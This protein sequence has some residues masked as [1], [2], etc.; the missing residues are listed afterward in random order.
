MENTIKRWFKR[1]KH[2]L[3]AT[4]EKCATRG[5]P[6]HVPY[7]IDYEDVEGSGR[8]GRRAYRCEKHKPA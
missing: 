6:E 4:C 7:V 1:G 3:V 8:S 5:G 2:G